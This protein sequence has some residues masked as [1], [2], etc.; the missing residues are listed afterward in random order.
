LAPAE[1]RAPTLQL[2]VVGAVAAGVVLVADALATF[3]V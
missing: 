2:L 3:A 1:K